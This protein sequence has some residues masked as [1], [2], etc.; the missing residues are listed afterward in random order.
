MTI[1]APLD[2]MSAGRSLAN[3]PAGDDGSANANGYGNSYGDCYSNCY[4]DGHGNGNGYTYT[5][6][7][8]YADNTDHHMGEPCGYSLC[9]SAKRRAPQRNRLGSGDI[10]LHACSGDRSARW[11]GSKPAC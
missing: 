2:A 1:G 6:S 8:S 7:H 3:T 10:C 11:H 4:R 5:Y 9:N